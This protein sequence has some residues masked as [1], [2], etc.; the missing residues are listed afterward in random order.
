MW[1]KHVESEVREAIKNGKTDKDRERKAS[2]RMRS[3]MT[4]PAEER[5]SEDNTVPPVGKFRDPAASFK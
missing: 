1:G 5:S 2:S 4:A 3:L